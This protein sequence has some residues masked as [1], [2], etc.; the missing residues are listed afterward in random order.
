MLGLGRI[1]NGVKWMKERIIMLVAD[2]V[3]VNRASFKAMFDQEYEVLEAENG[4]EALEI[5]GRQKVD[6]VILDVHMP[7]MSGSDVLGRMKADPDLRDIPVVVKTTTDENME[8]EMLKKGAD[9]FIFSPCEPEVVINRVKNIATRYVG[10]KKLLERRLEEERHLSTVR[11]HLITRIAQEAKDDVC[12][13]EAL[14]GG[15]AAE[16]NLG[17]EEIFGKILERTEHVRMMTAGILEEQ[18]ARVSGNPDKQDPFQLCGVVAETTGECKAA[19][20]ERGIRL[21]VKGGEI[22]CDNLIGDGKRLKQIWSRLLQKAYMN[23]EPGGSICTTYTEHSGEDGGIELEITVRGTID[24][25]EEYPIIKSL[26]EL[27]RGSMEVVS[28]HGGQILCKITLPFGMGKE[29]SVEKKSFDCLKTIVLDDNEVTRDYHAS[30]LARLGI[31]CEIVT[32]SADAV[33]LIKKAYVQGNSY[34]ICFVNWYMTGGENTIREIRS[35]C[36]PERMIITCST[37]DKE[38]D[39]ERMCLAGVD[40]VMERPVYHASMY[41]FLTGVCGK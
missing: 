15:K 22:F 4:K 40:Y 28:E 31:S 38:Q 1:G 36:P 18:L 37:S 13:I 30:M 26:V 19:C 14:C 33:Q 25:R 2:D 23:T 12:A 5:L 41:H 29:A 11:E 35:I 9:D 34:D 3:A 17:I 20:E 21:Q 27:L 24:S 39:E 10:G 7:V 32:N 8:V 16:G 6:I